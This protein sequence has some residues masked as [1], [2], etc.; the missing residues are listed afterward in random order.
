M[1]MHVVYHIKFLHK[2]ITKGSYAQLDTCAN[3]GASFLLDSTFMKPLKTC[4][5]YMACQLYNGH[6][7]ILTSFCIFTAYQLCMEHTNCKT[8]TLHT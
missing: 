3:L 2:L 5:N 6:L 1:D 4:H 8:P 7:P